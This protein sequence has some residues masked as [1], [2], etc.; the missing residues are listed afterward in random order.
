MSNNIE[1]KAI[2]ITGAAELANSITEPAFAKNIQKFYE[3]FAIP[4]DSFARAV[5]FA[6]RQSDDV[7]VNKILFGLTRQEL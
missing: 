1:G 3:A 2:V 4:A 7:D 6:M 5:D